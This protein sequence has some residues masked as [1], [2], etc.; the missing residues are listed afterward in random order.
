[1]SVIELE[2]K[3]ASGFVADRVLL[4]AGRVSA[5]NIIVIGGQTASGKSALALRL[6]EAIDGEI[7]GADSRQLYAGV[8]VASAGPDD[9][10]RRRIP[11]HLYEAFD[12]LTTTVTAGV[13][14][15][16]AD[17][18]INDIVARGKTAIVVGGTGLY[19]RSLRLGLGRDLP[20][21]DD[22]RAQLQSVL[23]DD[24]LDAIVAQLRSVDVDAANR[25]DL[26]NP[27]RV[28][29]A[30]EITMLGGDAG[31]RDLDA[32]LL[33][34]PRSIVAD[35]QWVLIEPAVEMV[36]AA[37]V[38]R[39]ETMFAH[40]LVEESAALST[41]LPP[42]HPLLTTMGT[43]EALQVHRGELDMAP[44]KAVVVTRTRQYAR[45]Q[46]T[47]FRKEP[48]WTRVAPDIVVSAI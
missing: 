43:A 6:A 28:L 26:R 37:I 47:W 32:M 18:A 12:P 9:D 2:E 17:A 38:R 16:A 1:M 4:G 10:E 23:D 5:P 29:R 19:L 39:V 8:S 25:I 14:V 22:V 3:A 42:T 11:H 30:L 15:A 24:G 7:V 34:L 31:A 33:Q 27:V 44:A 46:R 41:R 45:R 21:N 40:G 48:W 35:A 20:R 13:F 36:E